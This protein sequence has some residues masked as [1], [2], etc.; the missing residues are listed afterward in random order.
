MLLLTFK[1]SF[2]QFDANEGP[3]FSQYP[4]LLRIVCLISSLRLRQFGV[5]AFKL[6]V[7]EQK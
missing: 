6:A 4:W 3:R 1:I 7:K 5:V 2:Q